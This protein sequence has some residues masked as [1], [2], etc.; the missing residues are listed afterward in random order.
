MYAKR[1]FCLQLA[2][3]HVELAVGHVPKG[4]QSFW[5]GWR[6]V[7]GQG[8]LPWALSGY[9]SVA[10]EDAMVAPPTQMNQSGFEPLTS[11][12]S[13]VRSNQLSYEFRTNAKVGSAPPCA[14]GPA[15]QGMA[16]GH[17]P[18]RHPLG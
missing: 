8:T 3:G 4:T 11:R 12:L 17:M 5:S 2:V 6:R 13:S 9:A 10:A 14:G 7:I 1:L 16:Y 18:R 15:A